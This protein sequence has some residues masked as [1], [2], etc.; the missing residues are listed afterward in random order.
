MNETYPFTQGYSYEGYPNRTAPST[1]ASNPAE[2]NV[3]TMKDICRKYMNYHIVAHLNDGSKQEGILEDINNR[4]IILLIPEDV[5]E[6]DRQ[7]YGG[8]PR[9]R[10]YRRFL[11]PFPLFVFPFIVPF[12]FY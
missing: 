7:F 5:T 10:R 2:N 4:G 11:F 3:A 12:P 1:Q 8:R 9:F 6:N